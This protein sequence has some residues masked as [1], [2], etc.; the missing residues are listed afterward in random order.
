MTMD[1][2]C[3]VRPVEARQRRV[4][5]V[6]LW[7]NVAMFALELG[8]GLIAHSTALMADSVD[9]L[10][11]AIVYGFS[12]YVIGRGTQWQARGAL[13]KGAIMAAFAAGIA[14]EV[15]LKLA[16]GVTP[17]AELMTGTA[18]IALAANGSVLA[19]L[20]RHRADDLNMRSA[21]LCSR[22]DVISNA[23]V[24][25]AA[26]AVALTD[27]AWPDIVTGAAIAALFATSSLTIIR[28]ALKSTG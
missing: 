28:E 6:V 1:A 27:S 7:I 14:L 3:E 8:A 25:C 10:G 24:V 13:L 19:F 9:M 2:C 11:D 17:N 12:L 26:V 5:R 18:L 20:W 15:A 4:L 22:N 21:W 16:R 23:A